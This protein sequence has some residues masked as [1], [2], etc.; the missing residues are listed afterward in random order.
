MKAIVSCDQVVIFDMST[1]FLIDFIG[2][3]QTYPMVNPPINN[4]HY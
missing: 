2:N 3:R 4:L 1:M